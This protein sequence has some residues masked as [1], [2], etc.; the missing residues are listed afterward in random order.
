MFIVK[1]PGINSHLGSKGCEKAGN[2][3]LKVLKEGKFSNESGEQIIIEKLDLEE[4]HLDNSD[5]KLTNKLI[6]K[7]AFEI[8]ETK[9]KSVFLGGDHSVSYSLCK[10]FLDY[11]NENG[12]E[13]CLIIFDA[14]PDC[15]LYGKKEEIFP[16][17]RN[18]LR[19][20]V[21]QEFPTKNILIIGVRNLDKDE[22]EFLKSNQIRSI[23]I[24]S[25]LENIEETCEI[26]MEFSD[27]KELYL[28]LDIDILDPV[29]APGTDNLE[30]GGLT[31]R[32]FIYLIQRLNKIK[33][34]RAIDLVEINPL[35]D[36]EDLTLRLGAKI[37]SELI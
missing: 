4:I 26:I 22:K 5:L 19:K 17:N 27:R 7:N 23:S 12:K 30:A 13:P 11:S 25:L 1:V 9:P 16:E 35:K 18:W 6:Y 20:L 29:F 24:N 28:S 31:S 15:K 36:K 10:A 3:I 2:E 14:H 34:L 21:E 32:E 37:L 8:F 33:H